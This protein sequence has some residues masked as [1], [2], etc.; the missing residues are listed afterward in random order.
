MARDNC[1][2]DS[3]AKKLS[4]CAPSNLLTNQPTPSLI[5]TR[6]RGIITRSGVQ[7]SRR[8]QK[9]SNMQGKFDAVQFLHAQPP[10]ILSALLAL[11]DSPI[12]G[13]A[14]NSSNV[15]LV[16]TKG[17]IISLPQR[18]RLLLHSGVIS[19][20]NFQAFSPVNPGRFGFA[21]RGLTS[22]CGCTRPCLH[23]CILNSN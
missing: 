3:G 12:L 22:K 20:F 9:L 6:R 1:N 15:G 16:V 10:I 13:S 11:N 14:N 19:T 7:T 18:Q 5:A 2:P 21:N 23:C 8:I 17:L 4:S